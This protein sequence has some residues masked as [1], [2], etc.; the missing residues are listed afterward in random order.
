MDS[1]TSVRFCEKCQTRTS[2]QGD[3]C[4]ICNRPEPAPAPDTHKAPDDGTKKI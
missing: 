1:N 2:H 3:C 4:L